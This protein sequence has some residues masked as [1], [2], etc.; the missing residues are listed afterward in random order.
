MANLKGTYAGKRRKGQRGIMQLL[1]QLVMQG[2]INH[3]LTSRSDP[4]Q[5][6]VG[7][8]WFHEP[9]AA[10]QMGVARDFV[11][12]NLLRKRNAVQVL[13]DPLQWAG[14]RFLGVKGQMVRIFIFANQKVFV[15]TATPLPDCKSSHRQYTNR[16]VRCVP[17]HCIYKHNQ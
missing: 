3:T 4:D 8:P 16:R 6:P 15:T 11:R 13:M 17:I 9:H 10:E 5:I 7:S 2:W 1:M 12:L 14:K